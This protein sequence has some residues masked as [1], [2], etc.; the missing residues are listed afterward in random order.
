MYYDSLF[1]VDRLVE[2]GLGMAVANHLVNT[3]NENMPHHQSASLNKGET[4]NS[5]H[6]TNVYLEYLGKP[7]GPLDGR[8]ILKFHKDGMLTKDTL[9]WMPGMSKWEKIENIP[10]ILKIIA[11]SPY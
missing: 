10:L 9:A 1:T 5:L 7:I 11:L 8:E 6:I 3:F 4:S 2:F